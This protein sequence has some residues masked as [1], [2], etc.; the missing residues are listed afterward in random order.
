M[1]AGDEMKK[2]VVLGIGNRLMSDEGVGVR[3][4]ERLKEESGKYSEVEF[5]EAGTGGFS[6]IHLIRS[7]EKAVIID[8]AYM[9]EKPGTMRRFLPDE[10]KSIKEVS[11]QSLHESDILK[12]IEMSQQLGDGPREV[13]FFG[14]EPEY[15]GA[16]DKLSD[17]IEKR[18]EEYIRI[19]TE[20][21]TQK[22]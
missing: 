18:F 13:V 20:E 1:K 2:K 8:C 19:I 15:V 22:R 16:G 9:G 5:L 4:V 3:I 7:R 14:I 6:V 12:V 17:T 21:L 11:G 10:V